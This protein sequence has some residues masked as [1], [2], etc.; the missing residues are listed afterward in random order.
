MAVDTLACVTEAAPQL[1]RPVFPLCPGAPLSVP[2]SACGKPSPAET[3][4]PRL[5]DTSKAEP[6]TTHPSL[7]H[8]L[9]KQDDG[10]ENGFPNA[11]PCLPAVSETSVELIQLRGRS[12]LV[13]AHSNQQ[14]LPSGRSTN[15]VLVVQQLHKL[16]SVPRSHFNSLYGLAWIRVHTEDELRYKERARTNAAPAK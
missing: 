7:P 16:Q 3:Y 12:Y 8:S 4:P 9:H 14:L 10:P 5:R 15:S 2:P 11:Q 13:L 1:N 6:L